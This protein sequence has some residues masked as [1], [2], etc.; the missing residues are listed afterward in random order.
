MSSSKLVL[1]DFYADWCSTCQTMEPTIDAIQEK[2]GV[3]LE[4]LKI[5]TEENPQMAA[6]YHIRSVPTYILFKNGE[7]VWKVAGLLTKKEFIQTIEK[8]L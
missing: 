1:I 8:Q 5:N 2:F 3:Q 7:I 4:I 6:L